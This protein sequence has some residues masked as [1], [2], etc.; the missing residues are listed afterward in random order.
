MRFIIG[1]CSQFKVRLIGILWYSA[2][3]VL[4]FLGIQKLLDTSRRELIMVFFVRKIKHSWSQY[5]NR[6][7]Y[8]VYI[9]L[10]K[11]K[12]KRYPDILTVPFWFSTFILIF[13]RLIFFYKLSNRPRVV[14]PNWLTYKLTSR[15][16]L[17]QNS[18]WW[19]P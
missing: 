10:S 11:L 14:E 6:I 16:R 13:V 4:Q 17:H 9:K 15:W 1:F 5:S 19:N 7:L 8:T 12:P 2:N 18:F 3:F